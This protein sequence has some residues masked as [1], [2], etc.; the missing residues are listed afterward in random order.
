MS[1]PA[2]ASIV[3]VRMTC[4]LLRHLMLYDVK[5]QLE[6]EEQRLLPRP[7]QMCPSTG[8]TYDVYG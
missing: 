6:P 2:L 3:P 1:T 5:V 8:N 7:R 4:V